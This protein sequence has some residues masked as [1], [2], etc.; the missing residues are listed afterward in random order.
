MN[1]TT[2]PTHRT[3]LPGRGCAVICC[4]K[5]IANFYGGMRARGRPAPAPPAPRARA[6]AARLRRV[7]RV[8]RTAAIAV[9]R[10]TDTARTLATETH[11]I[12]SV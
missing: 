1:L 12:R 11:L 6:V 4:S 7:L 5:T 2:K 10:H 9:L 8:P 3:L